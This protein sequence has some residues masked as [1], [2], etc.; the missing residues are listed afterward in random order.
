L[1][2]ADVLQS[3]ADV[4]IALSNRN[5]TDLRARASGIDDAIEAVR[6]D[7]RS[8]RGALV[9]VK[10]LLLPELIELMTYVEPARRHV[11][12]RQHDIETIERHVDRRCRFDIVLHALDR[13]PGTR[14]AREGE[15]VKAVVDQFL[16]TCRVEDR[17][18]RINER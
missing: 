16:H 9:V 6:A 11:E 14:E 1:I 8:D 18:H 10:P 13:S 12:F 2:N 7:E 4:E 5:D 3:L 17:H 15:T